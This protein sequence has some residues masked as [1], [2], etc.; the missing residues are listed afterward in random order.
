M[1]TVDAGGVKREIS[2]LLL[3]DVKVGDYV[4]VHA[5]FAINK[6]DASEAE[7]T[8]NAIREA[9]GLIER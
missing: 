9:M 4:I 6:V 8:L 1:G 7:M 2:F 5:G 3:D